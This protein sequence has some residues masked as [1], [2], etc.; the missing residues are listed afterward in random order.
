MKTTEKMKFTTESI[1]MDM[2]KVVT[3]SQIPNTQDNFYEETRYLR[4]DVTT[5]KSYREV[6]IDKLNDKNI[7]GNVSRHSEFDS[8]FP[9][10]K[11]KYINRLKEFI[12]ENCE[13]DSGFILLFGST[14]TFERYKHLYTNVPK[15]L[16]D[17]IFIFVLADR[18]TD[19]ILVENELYADRVDRGRW[20]VERVLTPIKIYY[21]DKPMSSEEL[22]NCDGFDPL[23]ILKNKE[24]VNYHT[25]KNIINDII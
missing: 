19:D 17:G 7:S 11:I 6:L 5:D 15:I 10:Y 9:I 20:H 3:Y 25:V 24:H 8:K 23:E 1:N 12:S 4:G 16:D 22:L 21:G 13:S 14:N 2:W 18:S